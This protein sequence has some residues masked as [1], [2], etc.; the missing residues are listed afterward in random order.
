[1][2]ADRGD[3]APVGREGEILYARFVAGQGG[4]LLAG[5][6]VPDADGPI[7]AARGDRAAV[8][9]EGHGDVAADVPGHLPHDGSP[10][11]VPEPDRA[12]LLGGGEGRAVRGEGRV[13]DLRGR[14]IGY[15]ATPVRR[16]PE[17]E[18]AVGR[19]GGQREAVGGERQADVGHQVAPARDPMQL[20]AGAGVPD[21]DVPVVRRGDAAA[22]GGEGQRANPSRAVA[23]SHLGVGRRR[24]PELD[25]AIEASRRGEDA[26]GCEGHTVDESFVAVEGRVVSISGQVPS[27]DAPVLA[28]RDEL[29]AV[30]RE[31]KAADEASVAD[32][33]VEVSPRLAVPDPDRLVP[34]AGR[35]A[36]AVGTEN[37]GIHE[38][39]VSVQLMGRGCGTAPEMSQR[40]TTS[41]LARAIW[42]PSG[43]NA[44]PSTPPGG[45]AIGRPRAPPVRASRSRA[46][47]LA[48]YSLKCP[49]PVAIVRPSGAN[50]RPRIWTPC[51]AARH[52]SWPD[53]ASK[54]IRT[55]P[56][57]LPVNPCAA[58]SVR[59]SGE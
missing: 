2:P 6:D 21:A 27:T 43:A 18:R 31:R 55:E 45:P 47:P 38:V 42:R 53:S 22:V 50:A 41:R 59:P 11:D 52:S 3:A 15:P 54:R 35:Q 57:S 40:S 29:V 51:S 12:V 37:D 26:V 36:T 9:R 14:R 34:A 39:D 49:H 4:D 58:A 33:G 13:R 44:T 25:R 7:L 19:V 17:V 5:L 10:G 24:R 8:R 16:I 28:P 56:V 32:E 20:L 30:G 46:K 48:E 23:E 1:M